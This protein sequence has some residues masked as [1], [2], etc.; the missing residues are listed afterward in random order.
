VVGRSAAAAAFAVIKY[1]ERE[2]V[3]AGIGLRHERLF[4]YYFV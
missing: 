1:C 3:R 4:M 2:K